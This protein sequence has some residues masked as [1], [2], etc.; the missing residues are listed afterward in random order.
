MYW[1]PLVAHTIKNPS[2]VQE[3]WVWSLAWEDSPGRGHGN[4]LQDTCLENPYRQRCLVGYSP[5]GRKESDITK[6]LSISSVL[7]SASIISWIILHLKLWFLQWSCMDVRVGLWRRLN[8]EELM[9]LNCGVGEDSKSPL[10]CKEIKSVNPKRNQSWIF[11]ERTDAEAE[12]PIFWPPD[13]K[14]WVIGKDPNAGKDWRQEKRT[15]EDKMVGWYHWLKD[16]S[17][18]KLQEMGKHREAWPAIVHGVRKSWT[19]LSNWTTTKV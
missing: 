16:M 9:L 3:T 18:S 11:I 6:Q 12:A 10:D 7:H 14:I 13:A 5:W 8:A 2:A 19:Q 17:L 4:P 1:A 15:M